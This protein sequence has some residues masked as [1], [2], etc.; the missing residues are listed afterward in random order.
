MP[1]QQANELADV[2][3]EVLVSPNETDSNYEPAN[4]VDVVA[5]AGRDVRA[6]LEAVAVQLGRLADVL[7]KRDAEA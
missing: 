5:Q 3:R 4:L 1:K 7:A 6:G 2:L